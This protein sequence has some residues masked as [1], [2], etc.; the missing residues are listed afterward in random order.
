MSIVAR[1]SRFAVDA[2]ARD[3]SSRGIRDEFAAR[4]ACM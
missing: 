3:T 2:C 1:S 4:R